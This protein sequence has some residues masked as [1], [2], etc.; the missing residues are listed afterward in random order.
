MNKTTQ[1]T[2]VNAAKGGDKAA[3]EKLYGEYR[4]KLYFFAFKNAGTREAAEDIVSETFL[5]AMEKI[6]ALENAEAFGSWLY[7]IAYNRCMDYL[8]DSARTEHFETDEE[9]DNALNERSL[10]EPVM[11]PADFAEKGETKAQVREIIEGLDK[12]SRSA[13]ILYYYE[14]LSLKDTA[15]AMGISENAAKQ[16]IYKAR[17]KIKK[18][19]DKHFKGGMLCAVPLGAA[20]DC[21]VDTAYAASAK[22]A[23]VSTG[24]A[25]KAIAVAA[26]AAVG[27]GVPIGIYSATHEGSFGLFEGDG[28]SAAGENLNNSPN[29]FDSRNLVYSAM[30]Q[31][32]AID[33]CYY[34]FLEADGEVYYVT[35]D[36][37]TEEG[38]GMWSVYMGALEFD[39]EEYGQVEFIKTL[40]KERLDKIVKLTDEM[41]PSYEYDNIP[42]AE[43]MPKAQEDVSIATL[44]YPMTENGREFYTTSEYTG[45]LDFKVCK[46]ENAALIKQEIEQ[47][48]L[49]DQW[50]EWIGSQ[51]KDK[52]NNVQGEPELDTERL[53][54]MRE[55]IPDFSGVESVAFFLVDEDGNAFTAR[56]YPM[57]ISDDDEEGAFE[58]LERQLKESKATAAD[59][60]REQAGANSG[61]IEY[62]GRLTDEELEGVKMWLPEIDASA[63]YTRSAEASDDSTIQL[64]TIYAYI[65]QESGKSCVMLGDGG[66][67]KQS[68]FLGDV[69]A[70]R[71]EKIITESDVYMQWQLSESFVSPEL[72]TETLAYTVQYLDST[73]NGQNDHLI[74]KYLLI[75]ECG[76]AFY[77]DHVIMPDQWSEDST[78]EFFTELENRNAALKDK[79]HG[80]I[81]LGRLSDE[82]I[83]AIDKAT[84]DID[85]DSKIIK[86]ETLPQVVD[87]TSFIHNIYLPRETGTFTAEELIEYGESQGKRS[88]LGDES[89]RKL[90]SL[91]RQSDIYNYWQQLLIDSSA[92]PQP[93]QTAAAYE[94]ELTYKGKSYGLPERAYEIIEKALSDE[95]IKRTAQN[96]IMTEDDINSCKVSG[97][98]IGL[99]LDEKAQIGAFE[100]VSRVDIISQGETDYVTFSVDGGSVMSF[101]Y[102][103]KRELLALI[104]IEIPARETLEVVSF[105][106][107]TGSC[108]AVCD[109]T[110]LVS[111]GIDSKYYD[112]VSGL[113][114]MKCG[115]LISIIWS[116]EIA[117]SYP[118]QIMDA[119]PTNV[120]FLDND[121]VDENLERLIRECEKM[122]DY[123]KISARIKETEGL[124]DIE[125]EALIYLVGQELGM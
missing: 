5:A 52:D 86:A 68:T 39:P 8:N 15:K 77:A 64:Y 56:V 34:L 3:F 103:A 18:G 43:Y 67:A 27:V 29:S 108:L 57:Y 65:P 55:V 115:D 60:L 40:D 45:V 42:P 90:V 63:A 109:S 25:G 116:G 61:E 19:L 66:T 38:R 11:L 99:M 71:V 122:T 35:T 73:P 12:K 58:A 94:L 89:A 6:A 81:Y 119:E 33:R 7:S 4:N 49:F 54:Y 107:Q 93:Q 74:Y 111:F 112:T 59:E 123:D 14:E 117:E 20:L 28:S 98:Y 70:I 32:D 106:K 121:F 113:E 44:S 69:N 62:L 46:D 36:L 23:A 17:Q 16:R 13:V 76:N 102:S 83:K 96:M 50:I 85:A 118:G 51:N 95:E 124:S 79:L 114:K 48:G 2:L 82:E 84:E 88:E 91:I 24:F 110:G 80:I 22:A 31:Q 92:D 1:Q 97:L 120:I 104:G 72:H 125:A 87:N 53:I 105:D 30:W 37:T 100:N 10:A 21:S 101:P 75:D 41:E 47:S 9:R 26:V 78:K